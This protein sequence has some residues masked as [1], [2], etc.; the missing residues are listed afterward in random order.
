VFGY[1][2]N[3]EQFIKIEII[4]ILACFC[5]VIMMANPPAEEK[6]SKIHNVWM[7]VG[8]LSTVVTAG[9]D[10]LSAVFVRSM[11]NVHFSKILA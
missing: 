5:G 8:L 4:A 11:N 2:V 6:A 7:T 9:T 1:I 3:K 10:G